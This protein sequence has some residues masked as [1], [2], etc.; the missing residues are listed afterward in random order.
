MM[1][2]PDQF[3][4]MQK[5]MFDAA[6]SLAAKQ[7]ESIEK[8]VELNMQ[9]TKT[10]LAESTEQAKALMSAKDVKAFADVAVAA[11][12]PSA[13]KATAYAKHVYDIAQESGA[14]FAKMIEKQIADNQKQVQSA[15]EAFSKNAPMGSE[16]VVTLVKQAMTA[17][18]SAFD[19]VNKATKQAVEMAEANMVAATKVTTKARK[20]A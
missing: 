13:D 6:Q 4:Q 14:E 2:F 8:L 18:N 12:Q 19:Q 10:T 1:N 7:L 15:L 20:A 16:G 3:V 11:A 5:N 9:A 17:A